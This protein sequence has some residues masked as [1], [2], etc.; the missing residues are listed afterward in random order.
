[1]DTPTNL[2]PVT[3]D[4]CRKMGFRHR[5]YGD[6]TKDGPVWVLESL[7]SDILVVFNQ[8]G[9]E[10]HV[11]SLYLESNEPFGGTRGHA[12]VLENPTRED[13]MILDELTSRSFAPRTVE[14]Q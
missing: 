2:E 10:L 4:W 3:E 12:L 7:H 5:F 6:L 1:M 13:V 8:Y 9:G 11:V 14:H